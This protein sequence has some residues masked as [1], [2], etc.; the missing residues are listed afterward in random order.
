MNS[1]VDVPAADSRLTESAA[2]LDDSGV[3]NAVREYMAALEGGRRPDRTEFLARYPALAD[4][5]AE[6]LDGL[7]F[8]HSAA[9]HVR[10]LSEPTEP[11]TSGALPGTP[12]GD[13]RILREIGRGG[14]GVVYE[15]EQLSLARRVALKV[16]PFAS[17]LDAKQLQRFKNE[18]QAAAHLHHQSIV[19]VYATGCERGVHFYA[20]QFIEGR[21]LAAVI[22]EMRAQAQRRRPT[23][24]VQTTPWDKGQALLD[25]LPAVK[26]PP[27]DDSWATAPGLLAP[28]K[29]GETPVPASLQT[30]ISAD[31]STKDPAYFRAVARLGIQAAVALEHAHQLGVVHRDIKPANLLVD[32]HGNLW[33]TD[34]GLAQVQSNASLTLTGDLVGTVRYMS[35]EQTLAKRV[36]LDH[37]TDV[38]SLGVT[39]YELLTLEPAFNGRNRHEVVHQIAFEEPKRPRQLNKAIPAELETIVLKAM[40]KNPAER[41]ATAQEMADDLERFLKDEPIRAKR[42]G[43]ALRARKW[44]RR[45]KPLVASVAACLLVSLG[46]LA[47]S[48]GYVLRDRAALRAGLEQEVNRALQ[49]A[50]YLGSVGKWLEAGAAFERAQALLAGARDDGKLQQR[51][52]ELLADLK[53]AQTLETLRL[54]LADFTDESSYH[55]GRQ[56][57]YVGTQL[58]RG[59]AQAFHDYGIDVETLPG[60]EAAQRIRSR[61]IRAELAAALDEWALHLRFSRNTKDD[62]WKQLLEIAQAA[63]P[64]PERNQ[65]RVALEKID[66]EALKKLATSEKVKTWPPLA[67]ENLGTVLERMGAFQ[68]AAALLEQAQQKY[69]DN[70][71]INEE[72]SLCLSSLQPPKY[73][74]AARFAT[75]AVAIRPQSPGAHYSLGRV[76]RKKGSLK[77][78]QAE[79][80]TALRIRPKFSLAHNCLGNLSKDRGLLDQAISSYKNAIDL[81]PNVAMYHINLGAVLQEKGLADE[82]S[83]QFRRTIELD[84]EFAEPHF[85]L[86]LVFEKS[87]NADAAIG[88][89]RQAISRNPQYAEAHC[90]LAILLKGKGEL[91][92]AITHYRLSIAANPKNSQPHYNLGIALKAKGDVEGAIKEYR[93]AIQCDPKAGGAHQNLGS[94][95]AEKGDREGAIAELQLAVQSDPKNAGAHRGLANNLK[96]KGELNEAIKHYRQA[97]ALSPTDSDG[98][99][100]LG[101][102]L[103]EKGDPDGA[104]PEFR[105]AIQHNP[106]NAPAHYNLANVLK[107]KGEIDEALVHYREAVALCPNEARAHNGL[108]TGLAARHDVEGAIAEYRLAIKCNPAHSSAHYNLGTML[109]TKGDLGAAII[110]YRL[111]LQ[112][113]PKRLDAHYM[114]GNALYSKGDFDGA[115]SE[116]REAIH[117]RP[118]Y[119]DA[120]ANLGFALRHQGKFA[121]SLTTLRQAQALTAK[122]SPLESRLTHLVQE[123]ER[124]VALDIRLPAVLRGDDKL[125]DP[126]EMIEFARLAVYKELYGASAHW[127]A[128]AFGAKTELADNLKLGQRYDAACAAA[129]AGCGKGKDSP[130][131]DEEKRSGWR[132]QAIDW[133]RSDLVRWKKFLDSDT[134]E[135]R[136]AATAKLQH[137]QRDR[138]LA[139]LRD[140]AALAQLTEAERQA[141]KQLWADVAALLKE[142]NRPKPPEPSRIRSNSVEGKK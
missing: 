98:H 86:G 134:P 93:L 101:I 15:A 121:D 99:L 18:A 52:E 26:E 48:A 113:D 84:P 124:L 73:D 60:E 74:D 4:A 1:A 87:G 22:E 21:T 54:S 103:N 66:G 7:E 70:F 119:A 33:I 16:L 35:P 37:R 72:L 106:K 42:P 58:D 91:D 77:E 31:T 24:G 65:V 11:L 71:W 135:V 3:V 108:G 53:V 55:V 118:E 132:V 114:L 139:G 129:L 133:L 68:E 126:N 123:G 39:L 115:I 102:A 88:A 47:A 10:P 117:L 128:Q 140:D 23:K 127:F 12:L 61:F 110:E 6:V 125:V 51:A 5:L 44:A 83:A 67:Q 120:H 89:Y 56:T 80:E 36:L 82:A 2:K 29:S 104:F 130:S 13:F 112:H 59:Y 97:V 49:D 107:A 69:P 9:S 40:E 28:T 138:D 20:M 122:G 76:L 142:A 92:T 62:K 17:T 136:A 8:M 95:L 96:V 32:G 85:N 105:Q 30:G 41:Y 64:D 79:L 14:M 45:H 46:M 63:D 109:Q 116:Y 34:F 57:Y 38:Y 75:A 137:W 19:P 90:N 131:L 81:Q 111:A 43:L 50:Q 100:D 78:A 141:C 25:D 27:A 94:I